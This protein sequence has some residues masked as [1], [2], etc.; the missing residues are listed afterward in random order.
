MK[1]M[2]ARR[3]ALYAHVA[4][5]AA[6]V[7]CDLGLDESQAEHLGAAVADGLAEDFSGELITFPKDSHYKLSLRE[8]AILEAQRR[9]TPLYKLASDYDMTE[10]GLR[11]LLK[12]AIARDRAHR[13]QPLF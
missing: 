13:Q 6:E 11:R 8:Q 12:R 5:K 7:A 10:S 2:E 4:A 3:A 1:P 9:G